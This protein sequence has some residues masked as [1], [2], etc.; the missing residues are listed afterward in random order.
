[1]KVFA[2][3]VSL[4]ATME[5]KRE[6]GAYSFIHWHNGHGPCGVIMAC[7]CGCGRREIIYFRGRGHGGAEWTV[8]GTWPKVTLWPEL[9]FKDSAHWRGTLVD[10]EFRTIGSVV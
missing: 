7:P 6:P 10:G 3:E 2:H 5:L 8:D 1:M 4:L 9:T